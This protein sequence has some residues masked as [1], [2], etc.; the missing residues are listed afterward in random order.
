MRVDCTASHVLTTEEFHAVVVSCWPDFTV[1]PEDVQPLTDLTWRTVV[2]P[3]LARE[4]TDGTTTVWQN[5]A[6]VPVAGVPTDVVL[7]FDAATA[8]P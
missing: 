2:P 3:P 7:T 5:N 4:I 1:A 8:Q 6:T